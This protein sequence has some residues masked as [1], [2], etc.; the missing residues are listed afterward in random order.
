MNKKYLILGGVL[1]AV[2][3]VGY[4]LYKKFV[5]DKVT[6]MAT[7]VDQ[8]IAQAE[9]MAMAQAESMSSPSKPDMVIT[10]SSGSPV[11]AYTPSGAPLTNAELLQQYINR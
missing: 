6:K 4:L 7:E 8:D 10:S 5:T 9:A 2:A 1:I 3:G 11:S